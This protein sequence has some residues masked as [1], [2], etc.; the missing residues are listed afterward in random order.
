MGM[1]WIP[2]S[3]VFVFKINIKVDE[4]GKCVTKESLLASL[5]HEL[6]GRM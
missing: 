6:S 2:K 5:P 4:M 3:D 1:T